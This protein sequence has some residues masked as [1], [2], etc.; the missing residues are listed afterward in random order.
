MVDCGH[1]LS[2]NAHDV[3]QSVRE[4]TL[5]RALLADRRSITL[6]A[7]GGD[8]GRCPVWGTVVLGTAGY[9]GT[10]YRVLGTV[11]LGTLVLG[12][13]YWVLWHWVL[14]TWYCGT[15]HGVGTVAG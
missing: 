10:G 3:C 4:Y 11:A 6:R 7:R 14:G 15:E 9:C 13:W 12:N 1:S 8:C 5:E 2:Q